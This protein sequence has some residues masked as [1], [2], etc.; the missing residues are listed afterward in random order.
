[1]Y[2]LPFFMTSFISASVMKRLDVPL[3]SGRKA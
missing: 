3:E 2:T 1:M